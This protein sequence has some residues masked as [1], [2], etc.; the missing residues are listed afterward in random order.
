M[1]SNDIIWIMQHREIVEK[2]SQHCPCLDD[3]RI[4]RGDP[5]LEVEAHLQLLGELPLQPT[6][7]WDILN[8]LWR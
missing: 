1:N 6:L 5:D 8:A 2:R 7:W 4:D 3:T